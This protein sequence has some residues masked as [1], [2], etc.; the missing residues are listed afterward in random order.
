MK[1][2]LGATALALILAGC[3]GYSLPP[4]LA[5]Y[6]TDEQWECVKAGVAFTVVNSSSLDIQ[7]AALGIMSECGID[8]QAAATDAV[9]TA[10]EAAEIVEE[11]VE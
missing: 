5:D 1:K 10:L 6:I 2:P 3:A 8:P 7:K 11:E 9:T 4:A